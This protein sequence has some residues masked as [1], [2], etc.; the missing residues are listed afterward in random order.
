M[1]EGGGTFVVELAT[2]LRK[3]GLA[4]QLLREARVGWGKGHVG[5]LS[6]PLLLLLCQ[7][8][9]FCLSVFFSLRL[10]SFFRSL[11]DS[12]SLSLSLS[13][14]FLPRRPNQKLTDVSFQASNPLRLLFRLLLRL[15]FVFGAIL[16]DLGAVLDSPHP[17]G[18]LVTTPTYFPSTLPSRT[19]RKL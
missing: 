13:T 19:L 6:S 7:S 5:S 4:T 2:A 16:G 15:K 8:P 17:P 11:Y 14:D 18:G 3:G 12:L 9:L 1:G 10:F